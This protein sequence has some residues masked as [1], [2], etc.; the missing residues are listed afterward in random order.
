LAVNDI[1]VR[2]G[3]SL[4]DFH[5]ILAM[6]MKLQMYDFFNCGWETPEPHQGTGKSVLRWTVQM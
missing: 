4:L 3:L 6:C 2:S 5:D 1:K